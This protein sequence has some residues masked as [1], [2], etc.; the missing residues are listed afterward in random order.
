[1]YIDNKEL[2]ELPFI[3]ATTEI[4][5]NKLGVLQLYKEQLEH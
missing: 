3:I 4:P 1:M 2:G 5:K